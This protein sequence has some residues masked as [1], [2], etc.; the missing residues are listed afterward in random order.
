MNNDERLAYMK[1]V[2]RLEDP[3]LKRHAGI[4]DDH[5]CYELRVSD[6][7][8]HGVA[9]IKG[10]AFAACRSEDEERRLIENEVRGCIQFFTGPYRR[11]ELT[12]GSQACERDNPEPCGIVIA[13]DLVQNT[14]TVFWPD[15]STSTHSTN[16]LRFA[17]P[18][19]EAP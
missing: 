10:K 5:D 2:A 4:V 18:H 19:P 6:G 14:G 1:K 16:A 15:K 3:S 8:A 7:K 11:G 17:S 12:I 13:L 9:R